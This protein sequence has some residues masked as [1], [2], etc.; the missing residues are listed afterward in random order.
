MSSLQGQI[1]HQEQELPP[2]RTDLLSS[3]REAAG[4]RVRKGENEEQGQ[5]AS[6]L[7]QEWRIRWG[8]DGLEIRTSL[9]IGSSH[10]DA[11]WSL[12][13][14]HFTMIAVL[15]FNFWYL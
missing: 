3:S 11:L 7:L 2:M 13:L 8:W 4:I 10:G 1:H 5:I 9:S 15:T 12:P 6:E 14:N